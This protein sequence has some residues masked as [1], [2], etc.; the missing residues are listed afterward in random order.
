MAEDGYT[1]IYSLS[2][3]ELEP[4]KLEA[5]EAGIY[6]S[7]VCFPRCALNT[8]FYYLRVGVSSRFSIYS[9]AENLR[10]EVTDSVGVI[11]M[12]RQW[13]KTSVSA[14]QLPWVIQKNINRDS[15]RTDYVQTTAE[16]P[17]NRS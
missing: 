13:Q 9:V 15:F 8:G 6:R 2:D 11:Q 10:I 7:V 14:M 16:S 3:P 12:L 17:R 4:S 1:S 5:L